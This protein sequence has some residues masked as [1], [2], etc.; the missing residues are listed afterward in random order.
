[1]L[2]AIDQ[3]VTGSS[4]SFRTGVW[5]WRRLL[6]PSSLVWLVIA[7]LVAGVRPAGLMVVVLLALG[8]VVVVLAHWRLRRS[9][10]REAGKRSLLRTPG[11]VALAVLA[12]VVFGGVTAVLASIVLAVAA[13][14]LAGDGRLLVRLCLG[15]FVLAPCVAVGSRCGRWWAFL[16]AAGLVPILALSV[17][18]SGGPAGTGIGLAVVS[19]VSVAFALAAGSLQQELSN[20]QPTKARTRST[21]MSGDADPDQQS[22]RASQQAARA[23]V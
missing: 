7:V 3:S 8:L 2:R 20:A 21:P 6:L 10:D 16:G 23:V 19:V 15:V 18:V 1:V 11:E 17:L 4:V 12:V 22:R 14:S 5:K 13:S 9:A